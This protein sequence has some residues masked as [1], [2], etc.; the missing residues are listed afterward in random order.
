MPGCRSLK[1]C[2]EE[3]RLTP[4]DGRPLD[5]ARAPPARDAVKLPAADR[6]SLKADQGDLCMRLRSISIALAC[7]IALTVHDAA[8]AQAQKPAPPKTTQPP[9][10]T[11]PKSA[12][13]AKPATPRTKPATG[14]RGRGTA[15]GAAPGL[16]AAAK[17][18]LK[19][20][21]MLKDVAPATYNARFETSIGAFVVQV[22]R[23]WAPK[24]ADRF[25]NLVK[26][27]YYDGDRFFRV[28]P[29]FMVQFGINGDPSIQSAWVDANITDDPVK[30]SNKRGYITFAT[31]GP[32]T[33]TTQ[34][35]INFADNSRLDRQGFA[36]F[37]QVISGMEVVDKINAEYRENP[38]QGR[39]QMEGNAYLTKAFP[40][41]DYVRKATIEKAAPTPATPVQR[42]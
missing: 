36:P 1:I 5:N 41:L 32:G 11:P 8:L 40:R 9:K 29:D 7:G 22:H 13:P 28:L 14:Q 24:G 42:R 38:D 18:R 34:V 30:E 35:F 12:Q 25:Y 4:V 17:A 20:P 10:P 23:D 19:K 26:Y 2:G 37:G 15:R 6:R 31:A 21:A 33:R 39:I 3:L 16:S 27:G